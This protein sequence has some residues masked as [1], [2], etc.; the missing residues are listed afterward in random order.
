MIHDQNVLIA[1][2]V[3]CGVGILLMIIT[4]HQMVENPDGCCARYVLLFSP[5]ALY[6]LFSCHA[7]HAHVCSI[8]LVYAV[9]SLVALAAF[10]VPFAFLAEP[11]VVAVDVSDEHVNI[12][13]WTMEITRMTLSLVKDI[14]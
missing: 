6:S 12:K 1:V 9:L 14:V 7:A 13:C 11:A 5:V 10:F 3:L 8:P 4:A 2:G